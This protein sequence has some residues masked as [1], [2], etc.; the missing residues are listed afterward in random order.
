[1]L[2]M[3]KSVPDLVNRVYDPVSRQLINKVLSEID[4]FNHF[5]DRI[6]Q[7][8]DHTAPLHTSD[9][10]DNPMLGT[11]DRVTYIQNIRLNPENLEWEAV[12]HE[13]VAKAMDLKTLESKCPILY[14][15]PTGTTLTEYGQP[16]AI[17]LDCVMNTSNRSLAH[18]FLTGLYNTLDV[19][20]MIKRFDLIF[21]Y[22]LPV[23]IYTILYMVS[24]MMGNT[25]SQFIQF[26]KLH[27]AHNVGLLSNKYDDNRKGLIARKHVT[28]VLSKVETTQDQPEAVTKDQSVTSYR[29]NFTVTVQFVRPVCMYLLY[30]IVI[31][32]QM[33][34]GE[35]VTIT[36]EDKYGFPK[37]NSPFF[38]EHAFREMKSAERKEHYRVETVKVPWYDNWVCPGQSPVRKLNY[39]PF[40]TNVFTIDDEDNPQGETVIDLQNL[41]EGVTLTQEVL[42][43]IINADYNPLYFDGKYHISI[44]AD[45]MMVEPEYLSLDSANTVLHV[46]N[47]EKH[48]IYRLVLSVNKEIFIGHLNQLRVFN[49][50]IVVR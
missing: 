13:A 26:L 33:I 34:P 11:E 29:V 37:G 22:L 23:E 14:H 25:Q 49:I 31:N 47:R 41:G 17:T 43:E 10:N 45:N 39:F 35:A 18:E 48:H 28:D 8:S 40:L 12:Y 3:V 36:P 24:K 9:K 21:D 4:V 42:E 50:E 1:M 7:T 5:Q 2:T 16:C 20:D 46:P 38:D 30:P 27:S 19:G 15:F 6:Y 44:F 32:N